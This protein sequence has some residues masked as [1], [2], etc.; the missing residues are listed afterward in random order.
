MFGAN[1]IQVCGPVLAAAIGSGRRRW[2]FLSGRSLAKG[3]PTGR[4]FKLLKLLDKLREAGGPYLLISGMSGHLCRKG[5]K[6][7]RM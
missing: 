2:G 3:V 4:N 1:N 5:G 6:I 7:C